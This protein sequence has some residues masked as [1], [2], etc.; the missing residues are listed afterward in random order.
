MNR[1]TIYYSHPIAGKNK[2]DADYTHENVNCDIAT[3]NIL[4]LRK[5]FPQVRWYCPGEVEI[6]VQTAR[7]LQLLTV[8]QVLDIDF[9]IIKTRCR[10]GL[11]HPWEPSK[12]LNKEQER[13][14]EFEYPFVRLAPGTRSIKECDIGTIQ[15]LV[16]DVLEFW[17]KDI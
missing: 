17:K 11:L 3:K 12:G 10:G 2:P 16:K 13:F 1:P 5:T 9:H 6:P 14:V 8:D 4:W 15:K 7:I